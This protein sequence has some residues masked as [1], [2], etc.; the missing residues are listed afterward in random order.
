[1]RNCDRCAWFRCP[2]CHVVWCVPAVCRGEVFYHEGCEEVLQEVEEVGEGER[3]TRGVVS[4]FQG[5]SRDE[6]RPSAVR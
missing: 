4:W 1:V 6:V 2:K 3:V 5:P